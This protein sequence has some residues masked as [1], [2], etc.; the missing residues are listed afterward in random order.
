[1]PPPFAFTT[2]SSSRDASEEHSYSEL[3]VTWK[4]YRA[5][6]LERTKPR[7]VSLPNAVELESLQ[8]GDIERK[9]ITRSEALRKLSVEEVQRQ[10][11]GL[12][13]ERSGLTCDIDVRSDLGQQSSACGRRREWLVIER[14]PS[15]IFRRRDRLGYSTYR[16]GSYFCREGA[17]AEWHV[18]SIVVTEVRMIERIDEINSEVDLSLAFF[19]CKRPRKI[20]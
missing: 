13:A 12:R 15:V 6:S 17:H 11:A 20:L 4:E 7:I 14:R 9:W 3:N 16:L 8:R 5:T 1:M 19:R 2:S 18:A 10:T